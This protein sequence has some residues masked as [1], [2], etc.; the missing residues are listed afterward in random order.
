MLTNVGEPLGYNEVILASD[1]AKWEQLCRVN[2]ST[3]L[4]IVLC[5]DVT[6]PKVKNREK[7]KRR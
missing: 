3:F 5:R 7:G 4:R 2:W 6:Y 1:Q